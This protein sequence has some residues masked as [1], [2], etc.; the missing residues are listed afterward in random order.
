MTNEKKSEDK[1]AL[2]S[3]PAIVVVGFA[4]YL[5]FK[6]FN[7]D[8]ALWWYMPL[9]VASIALCGLSTAIMGLCLAKALESTYTPEDAEREV[10]ALL[11]K[12]S[13]R[14]RQSRTARR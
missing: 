2:W 5:A 12:D 10:A 1:W 6:V 8:H 13:Q 14:R 11:H 7:I 4:F 9:R 3:L